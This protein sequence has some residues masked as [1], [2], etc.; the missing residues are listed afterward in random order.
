MGVTEWILVGTCICVAFN[1]VFFSFVSW[2]V[3]GDAAKE[4]WRGR[5]VPWAHRGLDAVVDSLLQCALGMEETHVVDAGENREQ[6][7]GARE[8]EPG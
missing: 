6:P 7:C 1:V 4:W 3:F 5:A 2:W 8:G